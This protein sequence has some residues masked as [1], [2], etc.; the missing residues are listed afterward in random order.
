MHQTFTLAFLFLAACGTSE[1]VEPVPAAEHDLSPAKTAGDAMA[2][3]CPMHPEV[4]AA[5]AGDCSK[6][7]MKLVKPDEKP[8]KGHDGHEGHEGHAH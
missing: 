8:S 3:V 7:G 2:Y 4:S 5:E 1:P 6:C